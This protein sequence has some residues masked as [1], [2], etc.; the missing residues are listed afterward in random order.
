MKKII[1][2]NNFGESAQNLLE[3]LSRQ[4]PDSSGVW[5][6]V[7]GTVN[8]DE[9]DYYVIMDGAG[10]LP[11]KLDWSRVIYFQREPASVLTNYMGH[12]FPDDILFK[13]TYEHFYNVPTWWINLTFNELV[14]QYGYQW[15]KNDKRTR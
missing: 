6:D 12:N 10:P 8:F 14:N 15:K 11:P 2:L 1:F 5:G 9:A 7:E 13:G 3:R 4:T